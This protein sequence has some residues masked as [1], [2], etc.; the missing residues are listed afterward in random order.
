MTGAASGRQ[1]VALITGAS[2]GIGAEF[3]RVFAH[4]GHRLVL[5][6]RR[7]QRLRELADEI[8]A[9]G[10]PRPHVLA[11]DLSGPGASQRIAAELASLRAEPQ[12]VV[13]NAGFGMMGPAVELEPAR[14]LAM[15]DV[16]VR[17]VAELS[18]AFIDSLARHHGGILNVASVA[19][20]LPGPGM[21]VYF[22][23]KAFVLSFSEALHQE[24]SG[25]GIRVTTVCPGVV[26]T[27]FQARAGMKKMPM[28]DFLCT[29]PAD[30]AACG[31]A[32]LMQGQRVV[33][34]G[35]VNKLI[36]LLPRVLPRGIFLRAVARAQLSQFTPRKPSLS[37]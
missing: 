3:A 25:H 1:P 10:C 26:P 18:L 8:E 11:L 17:V 30:I 28:A 31:Y 23:S 7:E 34:P 20:Y 33:V 12:Y 29:P 9:T 37:A 16:N 2:A 32:A 35:L 6:A 36:T 27:E 24:L 14:Q 19:S 15:I 4:H 21:A 5:V 22:A 13:N